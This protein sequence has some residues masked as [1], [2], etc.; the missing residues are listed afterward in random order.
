VLAIQVQKHAKQQATISGDRSSTGSRAD[1]EAIADTSEFESCQTSFRHKS[2]LPQ[3]CCHR[4]LRLLFLRKVSMV[5]IFCL[6]TSAQSHPSSKL[7][8]H[9]AAAS[10]G[11]PSRASLQDLSHVIGACIALNRI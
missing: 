3:H 9:D 6:R 8:A 7:F 2:L 5:W 11:K 10:F 4:Q 1:A